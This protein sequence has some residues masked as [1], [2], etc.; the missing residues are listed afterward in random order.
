MRSGLAEPTSSPKIA[1]FRPPIHPAYAPLRLDTLVYTD[2]GLP[3]L[4]GGNG[5]LAAAPA[6][7]AVITVDALSVLAVPGLDGPLGNG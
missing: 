2:F 6:V 3:T 1:T 5:T 4:D 7:V